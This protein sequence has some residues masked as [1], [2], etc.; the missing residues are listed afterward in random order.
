MSNRLLGSSA[1]VLA[2]PVAGST[3]T[4][5]PSS[6]AAHTVPRTAASRSGL[7]PSSTAVVPVGVTVRT[8][9][10]CCSA[11]A[12]PAGRA[13]KVGRVTIAAATMAAARA[14][15]VPALPPPTVDPVREGGHRGAE[16][17]LL[18]V[19]LAVQVR[20]QLGV[21]VPAGRD[22]PS[23]VR[24]RARSAREACD[25]TAPWLMPSAWAISASLMSR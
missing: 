7:P 13:P 9:S 25:L 19:D 5:P 2:C 3:R 17:H 20:T 15:R 23:V 12:R 10:P 16:L 4:T 14:A 24:A 6:S 11:G 1:T 21:E 8:S 18:A 22:D